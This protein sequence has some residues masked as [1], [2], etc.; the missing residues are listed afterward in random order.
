MKDIFKKSSIFSIFLFLSFLM[1]GC[2]TLS[3]TGNDY[4]ATN[5]ENVKT[6]EDFL[7]NT[8]KKTSGNVNVKMGI[9]RT[10]VPELLALYVKIEN[11]S[12]ETPYVFK[13]ED[14]N[15]KNPSGNIQF[16]TSNN[17]LSIWQ[18]QENASMSAMGNISSTI[19]NM[20]GM[21]ANYNEF[22]QTMVQNSA[23][24]TSKS[25][26]NYLEA[27][28]NQILKHTVKTSTSISPRKSQYYYF[29]FE[30]TDKFPITVKYK[31]LVYQF[32]L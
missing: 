31:D 22:N 3:Y 8:Y 24:E 25:A 27:K 14:I 5:N 2:S 32:N 4:V 13:V 15:I 6:Q 19:T 26:Y 23:E 10:P 21:N 29:F 30:D 1:C 16:I 17:Y 11:L 28:G 7:F 12:Y 18:N 20:T 9:S